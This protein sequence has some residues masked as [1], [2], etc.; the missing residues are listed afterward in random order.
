M[1]R[2]F[3]QSRKQVKKLRDY[4]TNLGVKL[5]EG[6]TRGKSKTSGFSGKTWINKDGINKVISKSEIDRYLSTGWNSGKADKSNIKLE[7]VLDEF[8][9][10]P[11]YR[12]IRK[13]YKISIRYLYDLF[14]V[15][16]DDPILWWHRGKSIIHTKTPEWLQEKLKNAG[17]IRGKK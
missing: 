13:K 7:D 15:S 6:T 3:G 1:A 17:W 16:P 12:E 14:K 8:L 9:D 2:Y 11:S 10:H 4:Y 5:V